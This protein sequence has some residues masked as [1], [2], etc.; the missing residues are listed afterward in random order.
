M[1]GS[2][3]TFLPGVPWRWK[4]AINQSLLKGRGRLREG[5]ERVQ[6]RQGQPKGRKVCAYLGHGN[7]NLLLRLEGRVDSYWRE[8]LPP[9]SWGNRAKTANPA[10]GQTEGQPT[11]STEV[12][13]GPPFFF[14]K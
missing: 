11:L 9:I 13:F 7:L 8:V 6:V 1:C 4:G 12:T 2:P 3:W 14:F 10:S 5:P